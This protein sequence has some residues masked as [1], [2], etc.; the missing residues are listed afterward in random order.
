[1]TTTAARSCFQQRFHFIRAYRCMA[2]HVCGKTTSVSHRPCIKGRFAAR[3]AT[4]EALK[5][6][7]YSPDPFPLDV[8]LQDRTELHRRLASNTSQ[9]VATA[10]RTH[11][12]MPT[13]PN[14]PVSA[15]RRI[16]T[17]LAHGAAL[18]SAITTI[19]RRHGL[20]ESAVRQR[21]FSVN[22][23]TT[24]QLTTKLQ[25]QLAGLAIENVFSPNCT[26][27]AIDAISKGNEYGSFNFCSWAETGMPA[28]LTE[29]WRTLLRGRSFLSALKGL[30]I[31]FVAACY[32]ACAPLDS[33]AP[34]IKETFAS[35]LFL[36]GGVF[37]VTVTPADS[38]EN[39]VGVVQAAAHSNGYVTEQINGVR[40][41]PTMFFR[42]MRAVDDN[43]S[44]AD[45]PPPPPPVGDAT[46]DE[47]DVEPRRKRGRPPKKLETKKAKRPPPQPVPPEHRGYIASTN[48]PPYVMIIHLLLFGLPL[49]IGL[50]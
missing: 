24:D 4:M 29:A 28:S 36:D 41:F 46:E 35:M 2:N 44:E 14:G 48:S 8:L 27:V 25:S 19:A 40:F 37:T 47:N 42:I 45:A 18:A 6:I 15:E 38:A 17:N 12:D 50:L 26:D 16:L 32:D 49:N 33:I 34:A 9:L 30:Y 11:R 13:D 20:E 1:M 22:L 31:P 43:S 5:K 23:D 39:V 10:W 3:T 21:V 7:L